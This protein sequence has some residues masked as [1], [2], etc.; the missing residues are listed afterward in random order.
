[1]MS[2]AR[3]KGSGVPALANFAVPFYLCVHCHRAT[4]FDVREGVCLGVAHASHLERVE[5]V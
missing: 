4:K 2:H 5:N 1:M 3:T